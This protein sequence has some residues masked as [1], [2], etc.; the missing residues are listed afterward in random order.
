M[1]LRFAE[2][3]VGSSPPK[4]LLWRVVF[5]PHCERCLQRS[6]NVLQSRY[7]I[8]YDPLMI[9]ALDPGRNIGVAFVTVA[10]ELGFHKVLTL[11]ELERLELPEGV[12]VLV[13]DGTGSQVLQQ[14]LQKRRVGYEV[15]DEWGSSLAARSLYF[16]DYPPKGWQR[17]LPK[18]MRTPGGLID[19]YAAYALALS[20][21]AKRER[22]DQP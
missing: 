17:L 19:D 13:G 4:R 12:K 14:L 2:Q 7:A 22:S 1:A 6:Y 21:L 16:R 20:Y 3:M 9:V 18:G 10:G 15:V 5:G 11:G 8:A